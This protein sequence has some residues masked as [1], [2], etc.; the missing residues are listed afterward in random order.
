VER[1]GTVTTY[2]TWTAIRMRGSIAAACTGGGAGRT[3]A[4]TTPGIRAS[5]ACGACAVCGTVSVPSP[6]VCC[7]SVSSGISSC[8]PTSVATLN[9]I[10][11]ELKMKLQRHKRE[12]EVIFLY[13]SGK[14]F[15]AQSHCVLCTFLH[16]HYMYIFSHI[17]ILTWV[18]AGGRDSQPPE[19]FQ[20]KDKNNLIIK[21]YLIKYMLDFSYS[22]RNSYMHTCVLYYNLTCHLA[23]SIVLSKLRRS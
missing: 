8:V 12:T 9:R 6:R 13:L 1:R 20:G 21:K 22:Q 16:C 14:I 15:N 11:M 7:A 17:F 4:G 2:R 23:K 19:P 3:R 5:T 10:R 18:N